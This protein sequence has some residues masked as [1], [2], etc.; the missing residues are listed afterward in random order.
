[1]FVTEFGHA[2]DPILAG[3]AVIGE[4]AIVPAKT[5]GG[6]QIATLG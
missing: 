5:F 4:E 3:V 6:S 2:N 1:L